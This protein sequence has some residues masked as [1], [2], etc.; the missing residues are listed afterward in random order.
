MPCCPASLRAAGAVLSQSK[1]NT[2]PV[3]AA[4]PLMVLTLVMVGVGGYSFTQ[5]HMRGYRITGDDVAAIE[6]LAAKPAAAGRK[7]GTLT[8][9]GVTVRW[10]PG[11]AGPGGARLG[12]AWQGLEC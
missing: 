9:E 5:R 10:A 7:V 2:N 3:I 6:A 4:I 12:R 11:G 8:F 1:L